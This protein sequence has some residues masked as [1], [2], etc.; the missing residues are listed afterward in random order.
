MWLH[1]AFQRGNPRHLEKGEVHM[2]EPPIPAN[3]PA[4]PAPLQIGSSLI[5]LYVERKMKVYAVTDGEFASLSALNAQTTF[6]SSIGLAILASAISIWINALFYTDVPPAAFVAKVY[7]APA[8][9]VI[10]IVFFVL[11][12]YAHRARRSTWNQIKSKSSSPSSA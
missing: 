2:T 8:S 4:I 9:V 12:A 3:P 5:P 10:A 7:I 11:A 6:F 1:V